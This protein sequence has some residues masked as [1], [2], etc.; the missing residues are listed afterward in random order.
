[1]EL[2]SK[3]NLRRASGYRVMRDDDGSDHFD[4]ESDGRDDEYD[5][6]EGSN[7]EDEMSEEEEEEWDSK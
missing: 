3:K 2:R 6:D 1:M 7:E 4:S 5:G